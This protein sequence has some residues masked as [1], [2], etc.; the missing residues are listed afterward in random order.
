MACIFTSAYL[1]ANI[2]VLLNDVAETEWSDDELNK[3][4]Q[5]AAIDISTKALCYEVIDT[6]LAT[7]TGTLTYTEPTDCIKIHAVTTVPSDPTGTKEWGDNSADDYTG[8]MKDCLIYKAIIQN[9]DGVYIAV[10]CGSGVN[11]INRTVIQ[12]DI[13][14]DLEALGAATITS[15]ILYLKVY[16]MAG[17]HNVQ[18]FRLLQ[19]WGE[20]LVTWNFPWNTPGCGAAS[21]AGED[22][23]V[24]D[25]KATFEG[26][27]DTHTVGSYSSAIDITSLAQKWFA[28]T[29][30]EYGVLLKSLNENQSNWVRWD[31]SED[32][33]G[34]RPYLEITYTTG[35]VVGRHKGLGQIHPR[36]INHLPHNVV[37]EPVHWYHH[38]NKLGIWPL[39]DAVYGIRVY[40]SKVTED[41]T[42][43]P[44]E[45]RP[46]AIPYA[47]AKARLSKRSKKEFAMFMSVY[48]NSVR[49]YRQAIYNARLGA[50]AKDQFEIPD[51]RVINANA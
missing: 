30:K 19:D 12:F 40:H 39:S 25:R 1:L 23:G 33:D 38:H 36:L 9:D 15:A 26:S 18:A 49:Y 5:E 28:G 21:D 16:S 11:K 42:A 37:G 41:I 34:D 6:S 43:I 20:T 29:A 47:V 10:G 7:A 32:S 24:Y 35:V 46:L 17:T 27:D 3:W 44:C 22:D 4:V 50:G 45:L 8:K 13:K 51:K 48:Q 2:R 14:S 31:Q